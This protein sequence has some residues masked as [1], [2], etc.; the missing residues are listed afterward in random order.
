[1]HKFTTQLEDLASPILNEWYKKEF[2]KLLGIIDVS[3][4][5]DFQ[6]LGIDKI[7]V[8]R[9][10]DTPKPV[11]F[12][13]DEKVRNQAWDDII[14]EIW[15]KKEKEIPG[16]V[17]TCKADYIVYV[18]FDMEQRALLESPRFI[19]TVDFVSLVKTRD[20][21]LKEARNIGWTTVFKIIPK[22]DLP[23]KHPKNIA[24]ADFI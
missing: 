21:P 24:L 12:T 22:T 3:K 7:L 10:A 6:H 16:W 15:S 23:S 5:T 14:A 9:Y 17:W 19:P 20:Y 8:F 13:I 18:F 1:L 11:L 2:S 4:Q